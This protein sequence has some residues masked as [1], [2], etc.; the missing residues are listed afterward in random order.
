MQP[1][2]VQGCQASG[3][4]PELLLGWAG[5]EKGGGGVTK[6]L[7]T[8]VPAH[9]LRECHASEQHCFVISVLVGLYAVNI[10]FSGAVRVSLMQST[11]VF[12]ME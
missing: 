8:V 4:C 5:E 7:C 1:L 6:G 3:N 11:D 12:W 2:C 9:C 10:F